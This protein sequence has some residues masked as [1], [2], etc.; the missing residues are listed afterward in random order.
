LAN[1]DKSA[2]FD[3]EFDGV[4]VSEEAESD[5][6]NS[7]GVPSYLFEAVDD[8]PDTDTTAEVEESSKDDTVNRLGN[9]SW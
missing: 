7:L 9:T 5:D 1:S 6:E 8:S 2:S 4:E 3:P